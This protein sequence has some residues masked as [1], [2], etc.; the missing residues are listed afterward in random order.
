MLSVF[1]NWYAAQRARFTKE[2]L[3]WGENMKGIT[4]DLDFCVFFDFFSVYQDPRTP[5]QGGIYLFAKKW[6]NV[7]YGHRATTVFVLSDAPS[8]FKSDQGFVLRGGYKER[9]WCAFEHTVSDSLNLT[10]RSCR[11]LSY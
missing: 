8:A 10:R 4:Y 9:G 1:L 7:L 6:M 2:R 11:C 5:E 3:Y